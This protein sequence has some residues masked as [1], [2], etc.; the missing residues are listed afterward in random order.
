MSY[1]VITLRD[2]LK[3]VPALW[4]AQYAHHINK[5]IGCSRAREYTAL[6]AAVD[7]A[8]KLSDQ[9]L[10][11]K[12]DTIIGNNS[13]TTLRCDICGVYRTIVLDVEIGHD[14]GVDFV[15]CR[16]CLQEGLQ[17]VEE[18]EKE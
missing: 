5:D 9:E 14:Y 17:A 12:L 1:G 15:M 7:N 16:K 10:K 18:K 6:K 2:K 8:A 3:G 4:H 11:L 13:W